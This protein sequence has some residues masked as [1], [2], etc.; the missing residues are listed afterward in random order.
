MTWAEFLAHAWA[1]ILCF[2]FGA[3]T[4]ANLQ[5]LAE[6]RRRTQFIQRTHAEVE[7]E[8]EE[9]LRKYPEPGK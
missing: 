8:I 1:P 4:G 3:I 7:R 9:L 6:L 2:I 5:E